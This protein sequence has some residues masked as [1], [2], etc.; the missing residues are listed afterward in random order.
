MSVHVIAQIHVTDREALAAYRAEAGA[1]LARH[2]GSVVAGGPVADI[3]EAAN[4]AP[5]VA[6]LLAFP[7]VE[8]ARAWR[9]DAELAAVHELRN[10]AGASTIFV[11]PG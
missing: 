5:T 4:D 9:E 1:A 11:I 8:A 10:R 2:G 6:A 7:S 3:L